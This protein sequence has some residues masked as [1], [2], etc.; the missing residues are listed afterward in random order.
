[1]RALLISVGTGTTPSKR[2][3]KSLAEA[4]IKSI[5]HHNPDK[6]F[7]LV[8]QESEKTTIPKILPKLKNIQHELIRIDNPNNVQT[9]YENLRC[10]V[11]EIRK[12]HDQLII[13][14]T[15]GT[16]AM[17]AALTILATIFEAEEL[18]YI[19]GK[20]K[21]GIVQPG[22]EQ[23][24]PIHPYFILA[25]QKIKTAL[26]FFNTNQYST[27]IKILTEIKRTVKDPEITNRIHPILQLAKAYEQWDKFHHEKAFKIIQ[28]LKISK[29]S[30]NKQF[31]GQLLSMN[32]Q[33]KE[34][35]PYYIADLINNAERRAEEAKFDDAVARLYRTIE[36]I[37]QYELKRKYKIET[38]N[39][40]REQIPKKLLKEWGITPNTQKIKLPL[41]RD[42]ELL[43]AKD[44]PLGIKF[45]QDKKL[46]D[47][48]S[49]RNKSILA[50]NLKPVD[51]KTYQELR[52]KTEEYASL[53][54]KNLKQLMKKAKFIKWKS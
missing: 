37:A 46:K 15:S 29:L 12:N 31:L 43:A 36:L 16:K 35:E 33:G 51:R 13:D 14:Y 5:K 48:L 23:I 3:V 24:V 19:T 10:K 38:S 49:K 42:Y 50:H 28:K 7:F 21:A 54:I 30:G 53:T 45:I 26:K 47:L 1:M 2:A 8:T 9:I 44:N 25:E 22:T 18:S 41:Q 34:P 6:T 20:R 32:K 27:T 52:R 17:T 4:I 11:E 40:K 39:A